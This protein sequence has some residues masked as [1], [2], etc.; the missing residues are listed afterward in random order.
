MRTALAVAGG[1]GVGITRPPGG[2][3]DALGFGEGVA[4]TKVALMIEEN[5][6]SDYEGHGHGEECPA[7]PRSV[8]DGEP[9]GFW[10]EIDRYWDNDGDDSDDRDREGE[11]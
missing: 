2:C 9:A 4:E 10:N 8:V 5:G 1:E 3:K 7:D 6:E 11:A